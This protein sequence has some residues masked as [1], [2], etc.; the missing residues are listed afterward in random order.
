MGVTSSVTKSIENRAPRLHGHIKRMKEERVPK[1][2]VT[3]VTGRNNNKK[4][5]NNKKKTF[6]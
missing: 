4:K 5:K 6:M 3:L 1:N 2:N